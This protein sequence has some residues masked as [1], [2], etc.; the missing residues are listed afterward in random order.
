[1][2]RANEE[3]YTG[4]KGKITKMGVADCICSVQFSSIQGERV[5]EHF[6]KIF[7]QQIVLINVYGLATVYLNDFNA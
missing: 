2:E 7:A 3:H 6:D 5:R 1:M 4:F